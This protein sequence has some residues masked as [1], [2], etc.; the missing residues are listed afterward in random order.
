MNIKSKTYIIIWVLAVTGIL[1]YLGYLVYRVDPYFHYHKPLTDKYYY[2][3]NNDRVQNDGIIKHFDYDALITGTSMVEN[4]YTSEMDELFNVKSIKVPFDGGSYKEINDN[5]KT[6]L[7]YNPDLKIIVRGLDVYRFFDDKDAMWSGLDT[8]LSYLYD[9]NIFNDIKYLCNRDVIW[10][11]TYIMMLQKNEEGF[12]PGITSFD[13]YK[14]WHYNYTYG[15]KTLFPDGVYTVESANTEHLTDEEKEIIYENITQNVTSLAKQYP[16]VKFYY[17]Y[18]PYSVAWWKAIKEYGTL[19]KW[20]EAKEYITEL[21]L[22]EENI[23]L[24]S[25]DNRYEITDDLNNYMDM[26]H[27]AQW[28]NSIMLKWMRGDK[29]R[30]T[31]ENYKEDINDELNHYL[32]FDYMSLN[33]QE[34]YED[35]FYAAELLTHELSD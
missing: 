28:V 26:T 34:D 25:F 32:S 11:R 1:G 8:D 29:C 2:E 27:Y 12:V 30:L 21:I 19:Y 13:D 23:Y 18:T 6:A 24:F 9:S 17:F 16:D 3:L 14:R 15:V 33:N 4:F 35:D 5:L 31:K 20:F 22:E 10:N 7:K